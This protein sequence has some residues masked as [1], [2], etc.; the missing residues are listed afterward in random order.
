VQIGEG[1]DHTQYIVNG[2]KVPPYHFI[3][4]RVM[5]DGDGGA[6]IGNAVQLHAA[7]DRIHARFFKHLPIS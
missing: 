4:H 7:I 6:S 2:V 1:N 5:S 3:S